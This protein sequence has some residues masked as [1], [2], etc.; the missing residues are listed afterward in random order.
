MADVTAASTVAYGNLTS[1]GGVPKVALAR[2]V[3]TGLV[4]ATVNAST[5]AA[6]GA[7]GVEV[8]AAWVSCGTRR[9]AAGEPGV[10]PGELWGRGGFGGKGVGRRRALWS[11]LQSQ[12]SDTWS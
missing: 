9:L 12:S 2:D 4:R 6:T 11:R 7:C 1:S 5:G 8:G 10:G 3:S